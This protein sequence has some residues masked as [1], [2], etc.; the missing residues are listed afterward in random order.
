[1]G[2][3][4]RSL[5]VGCKRAANM[6]KDLGWSPSQCLK[7]RLQIREQQLECAAMMIMRDNPSRDAPEPFNTVGVRII[8]RCIHQVQMLFQ[9]GEHAANKQRASRSMGLELVGNHD[10]HSPS[11]F[12][13]RHSTPHLLAEHI[14]G[15]SG[16]N[17]AIEPAIT[18]VQQAKPI[19][20]PIIPRRFDQA[21]PAAPFSRP[22]PRKGRMKSHLHLILQIQVSAWEEREQPRQVGGKLIP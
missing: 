22:E 12:G 2:K 13:T 9:F 3:W 17:P 4:Q 15:A 20:L 6:P 5:L 21:L 19:H 18:P 10:G 8:G 16:S 14:S 1:M 11:L 7:M